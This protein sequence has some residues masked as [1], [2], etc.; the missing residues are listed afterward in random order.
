MSRTL[1]RENLPSDV[2]TLVG[3]RRELDSAARHLS[4]SRLVTL[5]G[6][7]GVGKSRLALAVGQRLRRGFADGVWLVE[8]AEL[9]RSELLAVSVMH[10]LAPDHVGE[11][12][13]D[14]VGYVGDKQLLLILD[15][16]EHLGDSPAK[17]VDQLLRHCPNARVLATS[18]EALRM[19]G[20]TLYEIPPL[21]V[22]PADEV[23]TRE[24]ARS[25]ESVELFCERAAA[26]A[27]WFVLTDE[28][29]PQI[30]AICRLLDGLPLAVELAAMGMRTLTPEQLLERYD[31]IYRVLTHG[32]R[33]VAPRHQTLLAAVSWSHD[34]CSPEARELWARLSC[35]SG[36]IDLEAAERVCGF[37]PLT[38]DEV[39]PYLT[40]L[41]EKS[42]VTFDGTQYKMLETLR[43]FGRQRLNDGGSAPQLDDKHFEYVLDL[44]RRLEA[45]WFGS[46]QR[47]ILDEVR[48]NL[49]NLRKALSHAESSPELHSAALEV[50]ISLWSYWIP[51]GQQ[52]EGRHWFNVFLASA[53]DST[54]G[55][56]AARWVNGYL[57]TIEGAPRECF[58]QVDAG[59]ALAER[60]GDRTGLARNLHVR[61][62]MK[63]LIID[64]HAALDDLRTA[65]E[66]ERE[67]GPHNPYLAPP[68]NS[69]GAALCY[70]E[71]VDEA[72]AVLTE[73]VELSTLH[74]EQ[75]MARGPPCSS[76]WRI[77]SGAVPTTRRHDCAPHCPPNGRWA[78]SSDLRTRSKCSVGPL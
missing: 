35:F 77:G 74:G 2:T 42:V 21:S 57:A 38:E 27:P 68:L 17:L 49:A 55:L 73:E 36:G 11:S 18:R 64:V 13:D 34:L 46:H 78:T 5:V 43:Q 32:S 59:I 1:R 31:R 53:T 48:R 72:V 66:L 44:A 24:R 25:F 65:V 56:V 23:T 16:C 20:E 76:A 39:L 8:L 6:T 51:C 61:G 37:E 67:L 9:T 50:L 29:L 28:N 40:E 26:A 69:L 45:S 52:R 22:P 30:L 71:Q 7:G 47:V 19:P 41:V 58:D 4:E 12:E 60:L 15:N 70:E 14:L 63:L 75:W 33:A 62:L 3:R 54:P 10:V